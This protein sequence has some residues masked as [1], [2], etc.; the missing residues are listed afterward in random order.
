MKD[1]P[2]HAISMLIWMIG[3]GIMA[4]ITISEHVEG[5]T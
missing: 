5:K 4:S 1:L 3:L 2:D